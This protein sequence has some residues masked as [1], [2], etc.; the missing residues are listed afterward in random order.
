[1]TNPEVSITSYHRAS[2]HN[3]AFSVKYRLGAA[4][5]LN[6]AATNLFSR[7]H[8]KGSA[9]SELVMKNAARRWPRPE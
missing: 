8:D 3:I 4:M 2:A 6:R 9:G 7:P 5:T 1:M